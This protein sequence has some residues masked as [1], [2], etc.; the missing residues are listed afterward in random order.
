MPTITINLAEIFFEYFGGFCIGIILGLID[1]WKPK[2]YHAIL[3]AM[4]VIVAVAFILIP[5]AGAELA[6]VGAGEPFLT[7]IAYPVGIFCGLYFGRYLY[8]DIF[9]DTHDSVG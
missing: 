4:V 1:A 7:N 9:S 5:T 8:N 2:L 6:A 3:L